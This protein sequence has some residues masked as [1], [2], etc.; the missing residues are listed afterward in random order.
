M[1]AL[2]PALFV[3]IKKLAI[4]VPSFTTFKM[5]SRLVRAWGK[6]ALIIPFYLKTC[7]NLFILALFYLNQFHITHDKYM[8]APNAPIIKAIA[9]TSAKF[10]PKTIK[11]SAPSIL[12]SFIFCVTIKDQYYEKDIICHRT[13]GGL[14]AI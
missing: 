2:P 6:I 11:R 12:L 7:P 9:I 4:K 10:L 13:A 8:S 14:F 3:L 5:S 1:D